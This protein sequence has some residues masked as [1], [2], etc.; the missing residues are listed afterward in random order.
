MAISMVG[1]ST[2][3]KWLLGLLAL[4]CLAFYLPSN[5]RAAE[6]AEIIPVPNSGFEQD[7]VSGKIPSWGYFSG[8][9]QTGL[10]MSETTKFAGNRSMKIDKTQTGALGA[11][12]V[13]LAVTPGKSY[14]A[15]VKLYVESFTGAPTLWIRWYNTAGQPLNKQA[16]STISAPPLNKWLDIRVQGIAPSDAAFATVFVYGSTGVLMTAYVDETQFYRVADTIAVINPGFEDPT[17]GATIPGWGLFSGTPASS[18][19]IS[20]AEQNS[21]LSSLLIDDTYTDKAVGLGTQAISVKPD[22]IYEANASIY[23]VSGGAVNLYLK[24]YNSSGSEI[25]TSSVSYGTPL[26][27]WSQL[28]IE[29]IAPDNATTAKVLLYSGVATL[30]KAYFDDVSFSY[31]GDA[32]K[33]PFKYGAPVDLGKATLTATTLGGAI[34]NGELYFVANGNPGTFYAVDAATGVIN[35]SEPVPGTTETWAVTVGAD[36]KVYFGATNNRM[37]WK[38]DPV[39]QKV[40]LIGNNPSNNFL[41]DLDASSNGLIYGSTYPNAKVFTY[42]TNTSLFADLG[43]MHPTE[44]YARGAGVTDQYLYVGIGSKKHLMR[45]DR[46]SG[47]KIEIQLPFTGMDDFVHNI[48]PYNGLLYIAHGTSLAVVNELTFEVKK[49]I[50]YTAPEAFDGKISPPSPYDANLLYYRNKF[51]NNLWAYNVSTNTVGPVTAQDTLPVAG[52]KAIDWITLPGVGQVLATLYDNGKYTLYNPNDNSI[53]TFQVAMARDG[54]NIQSMAEGPDHKLYLGGYI[55]GM[56]VFNESTQS[57]DVQASSPKSPHQVEEIGFLNGKTYFG[58]Y[59]GARVYRYDASLPYNYGETKANNPGLVYTIPQSQDRPYA[60]ASGDN[61]L[62]IGT[63]PVYGNMGGSLTI[64]NETTDKWT[65]TRNVVEDQSIIALAYKDGVV[66][67]GTSIEGGLGTTT[68]TTAVAKL[69]KWDVATSTKLDE[70]VPVIPGLTSPRLLGGLS[71]GPDGLLW[72]GAWGKDDQ[73][74]QISA[75]YAMNPGTNAVMKSKLLYPNASGGSTWRSFYLRWGQDGLL[76]TTIA[77]YVT[78]IDPVTMKARKLVDTQTNLMDLG[79]DGSIYYT[80]GPILFKLPVPLAQASISMAK[81][82][83]EQEQSEPV[84]SSGTLVN[85]LP[86]ILAGGTTSFTSSDPTVLS[87][88]YG[89]AK[90]LKAGTANVFADITLGGTTIRTNTIGVTVTRPLVIDP[91]FTADKTTPT[92]TDVIVTIGYPTN[93]AVKEY[94]LGASGAWTAYTSPIA[95][96]DNN[97]L[98]AKATDAAGNVSDETSYVVSNIDKIAPVTTASLSPLQPDGPNGT[99]ASPVTVTLNSSDSS[100]TVT[101]TVYSLDNGTTW[102]LYTSPITFDKQGQVKVSYKSIDLAGNVES[103]QMVSFTLSSTAVKVQLKDSS[104]NPLSGGVVSY[105]DGGWKDFGTTDASGSVSKTLPNKSY[106]FSMKYEG[107]IKEKVQNT[108]ADAV[109]AFQTVKVKLQLKDSQGNPL[110]VGSASYYAGNWRTIGTTSGGEISKELLPGS[111]T[112]DMTYEGTHKE[113]EQNTETD[114]V[115]AF[116]TVKV[117]LQLK[118]S[119]GNPLDV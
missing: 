54:V 26:N 88:V 68:P 13:K 118:D 82:T 73:G 66:Y 104:G 8:G 64:Y 12:S 84:I 24:F 112:F 27:T 100:S 2:F 50:A 62:F 75:I 59:G 92:N 61:K 77:R 78:A 58:A 10:S 23:L 115:I 35:H 20:K 25:G 3:S 85:G 43:S 101:N 53:Q 106:T 18:V 31:K 117:K 22:G 109:I 90:A 72:G 41:W 56:S 34:G 33:L 89:Q 32:L 40:T 44:Q 71:F 69:F 76:Y 55:D 7:L 110:D 81:V 36:H 114:A 21:G 42:D 16:T 47:E 79:V 65:S 5:V 30:S 107:T 19:S 74:G 70:F 48:S 60:F 9:I 14:E 15:V 28:K 86:A 4:L 1:R 49:Q 96:S 83:L 99:Y 103:P 95:V 80:S 11:E 87:V 93:A 105:Y 39:S 102:Q 119:Q 37:F 111:Y 108:G 67:G 6:A 52:S 63:V 29:G 91:T 97:T 116:Q 38:Y 17:S 45:M 94:K 113:K 51:S 46:N 98:Y 57:Y